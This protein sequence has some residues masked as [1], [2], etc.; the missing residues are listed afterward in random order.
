MCSSDLAGIHTDGLIKSEE[1]YTAFDTQR[2]LNRP[3]GVVITD[4]CGAAGIKHWLDNHYGLNVSKDDV[5]L[6]EILERVTDEYDTGRTTAISDNEM[7]H[8][9]K[10]VFDRS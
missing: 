10:E 9:Y 1:I 3:V 2:I 6:T 5:R 7:R 4:K 8:W